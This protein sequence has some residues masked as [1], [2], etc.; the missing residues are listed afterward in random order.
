MDIQEN[1]GT[2]GDDMS[3]NKVYHMTTCPDCGGR[4]GE[5]DEG[6]WLECYKCRGTGQID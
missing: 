2:I 3:H 6:T 1:K 4:G 5:F